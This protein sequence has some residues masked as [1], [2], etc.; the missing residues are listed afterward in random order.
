MLL[1]LI[2]RDEDLA[3]AARAVPRAP[4]A[5]VTAD[6]MSGPWIWLLCCLSFCGVTVNQA[7]GTLAIV[8]FLA[9]WTLIIIPRLKEFAGMVARDWSLFCLPAL[10]LFSVLWSTNRYISLRYSTE[11]VITVFVGIAAARLVERRTLLTSMMIGVAAVVFAGILH[12]V[13]KGTIHLSLSAKAAE[14]GF[15]NSKNQLGSYSTVIFLL[16]FYFMIFNKKSMMLRIV[17]AGIFFPSIVSIVLAK[18]GGV[19]VSIFITFVLSVTLLFYKRNKF[20]SIVFFLM[21]TLLALVFL[22]YGGGASGVFSGAL[23][24]LG[25]DSTLT[26]RTDLWAL[27]LDV[28]G[29]YPVTGIGYHAF[30]VVGNPLAEAMWAK[31][32]ISG[33]TGFHFHDTYLEIGVE[34]GLTGLLLV[35]ILVLR[36]MFRAGMVFVEGKN[37]VNVPLSMI[38]FYYGFLSSVEVEFVNEFILSTVILC[39]CSSRVPP[40]RESAVGVGKFLST[41][42]PDKRLEADRLAGTYA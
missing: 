25:K 39:I 3:L 7:V 14:E 2:D 26:G 6:T 4:A 31:F 28:I 23:S 29:D 41:G 30:W 8:L 33:R 19:Y 35:L 37:W 42:Q 38:M 16:S 9:P 32:Q 10:G 11:Y 13:Y 21:S 18:S 12:D 22:V 24:I 15:F 1:Q 36:S 20:L 40:K 5:E 27:A 34:L 17:S